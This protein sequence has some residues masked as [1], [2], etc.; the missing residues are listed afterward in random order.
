MGMTFVQLGY[1]YVYI[2]VVESEIN[3]S[4]TTLVFDKAPFTW[5][6]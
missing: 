4:C 2:Y 6:L 3:G 5:L 1:Q